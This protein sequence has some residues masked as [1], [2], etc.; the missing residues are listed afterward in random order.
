MVT[1]G[2]SGAT[3]GAIVTGVDLANLDEPA[4]HAVEAAFL[5]HAVLV[6]PGQDLSADEQ[7]FMEEVAYIIYFL[8]GLV[9]DEVR[10][11]KLFL[12]SKF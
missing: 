2:P 3:L 9:K 4:W 5:D 6:F 12:S 10:L 11:I 1:V 8:V 7:R